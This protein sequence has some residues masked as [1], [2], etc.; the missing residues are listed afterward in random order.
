MIKIRGVDR[1]YHMNKQH[2]VTINVN[3]TYLTEQEILGM[4]A[5][6]DALTK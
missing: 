2:W 5:E 6:S 3:D 4:L 1:G